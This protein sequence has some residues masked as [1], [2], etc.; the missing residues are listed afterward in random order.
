[1][2]DNYDYN[3]IVDENKNTKD[4]KKKKKSSAGKVFATIGLA[5]LFGVFA[6]CAFKGTNAIFSFISQKREARIEKNE[7]ELNGLRENQKEKSEDT[8]VKSDK[9]T[10]VQKIS[11]VITKDPVNASADGNISQVSVVAKET[12]PSIVAIT[13]K[14]VQEMI[15]LYGMGIQQYESTSAGS[16]IIIGQNDTELLIVTNAHVVEGANELSVAFIDNEVY[17]AQVK[18]SDTSNDLA[19]IAVE[20]NDISGG[21]LDEIKVATLGDSNSLE[22]GEPVVAIGN[23]LGYGQSVTTGIVSA[24]NRSINDNNEGKS[25]IQTDAAINPGNSGGA[26]LNMKG[27]VVGIN[28]A[29]MANTLIEG[30]GYAIPISAANPIV[31]DL[32]NLTTRSVVDESEVGYVGISGL[33]VTDDVNKAYGIPKGIY[34][35]EVTKDSPAE[36]AGIQKGDIILKFDGM[37]IDSQKKLRERL[38]YYKAGEVVDILIV[39]SGDGE[40]EEKTVSV[41]LGSRKEWEEKAESESESANVEK[42]GDEGGETLQEPYDNEQSGQKSGEFKIGPNTFRY[43][44]PDNLFDF[45]GR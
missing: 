35:T 44:V 25:Y 36:E 8:T 15:S 24:L 41:T 4:N 18:G 22:I 26:L 23:A 38:D 6:S 34:V 29:K 14:S 43:S 37:A 40:Y 10:E 32:M 7:E 28:S 45:F 27:E 39:R 12:M 13:N 20:L 1:M 42:R 19:I 3:D 16:G 31:E 17:S 21:T 33:T 30:M 11:D 5:I 9:N 2:S